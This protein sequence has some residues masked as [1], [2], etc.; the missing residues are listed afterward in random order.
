MAI[1]GSL[2]LK[3]DNGEWTHL[4]EIR[5]G[6]VTI[7][8]SE[9]ELDAGIKAWGSEPITVSEFE[10]SWHNEPVLVLP[11][12][13]EAESSDGDDYHS[14]DELYYYRML[15]NALAFNTWA[16]EPW[17]Y[18][19]V[20]KSWKHSDGEDCFGGGWFIVVAELPTGQIT[21]HYEAK[22]WDLFKIP[23]VEVAPYYDG[24]TPEEAAERMKAYLES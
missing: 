19:Q 12:F 22:H 11:G 20:S 8:F 10:M 3:D 13:E 9:I 16:E 23:E 21:N 2:Y 24:H 15:Y 1:V 5:E 18:P 4:G 6:D 7:D 17:N 14:M